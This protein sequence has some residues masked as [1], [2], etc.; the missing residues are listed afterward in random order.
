[1]TETSMPLIELLQKPDDGDF[2]RAIAE[3]VLQLLMEHDVEGLVGAGRYE[4]GEGRLTWR[5][6]SRDRELKTRLGV[7]NLR[8]PKLKARTSP[9]SSSRAGPRRRRWWR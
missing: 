5:N 9:V 4:R 2:L 8:V 6:G 7:L 1:M 3:A